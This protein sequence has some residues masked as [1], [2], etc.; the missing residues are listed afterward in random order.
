MGNAF[1]RERSF[2]KTLDLVYGVTT[3]PDKWLSDLDGGNPLP[4]ICYTTIIPPADSVNIFSKLTTQERIMLN[5]ETIE[6]FEDRDNAMMLLSQELSYRESFFS[7]LIRDC[8]DEQ[9]IGD[10][11]VVDTD[12]FLLSSIRPTPVPDVDSFSSG[13]KSNSVPLECVQ[14]AEPD[15]DALDDEAAH[16]PENEDDGKS[17]TFEKLDLVLYLVSPY[18]NCEDKILLDIA[19]ESSSLRAS[20]F[21]AAIQLCANDRVDAVVDISVDIYTDIKTNRSKE[22]QGSPYIGWIFGKSFNIKH[23]PP[24]A[25]GTISRSCVCNTSLRHLYQ[26]KSYRRLRGIARSLDD[27]PRKRSL[28]VLGYNFVHTLTMC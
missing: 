17:P 1:M 25:L 23:R 9:P 11:C 19:I 28:T 2:L 14:A 27:P 5:A 10:R 24:L 15:K 12:G 4:V 7:C 6:L 26:R 18:L 21:V 3:Y 20:P 8:Q 13:D 16:E 22:V